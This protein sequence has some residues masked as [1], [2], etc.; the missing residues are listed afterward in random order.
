MKNSTKT[1]IYK[2]K[3]FFLFLTISIIN[4]LFVFSSCKKDEDS[5]L[6]LNFM[7]SSDN[8]NLDSKT[9]DIKCSTSKID[10]IANSKKYCPLGLL[11]DPIFGLVK[12]DMAFQLKLSVANTDFKGIK[13]DNLKSLELHLYNYSCYGDSMANQ[14]IKVYRLKK[15]LD[16]KKTYYSNYQF[17]TAETDMQFI[18][19]ATIKYDTSRV[20]KIQ[21]PMWLAEEFINSANKPHFVSD[22][23]FIE[24]F[25]GLYLTSDVAAAGSG[26]I[27]TMQTN[28][29]KSKL[30]MTYK[31]DSVVNYEF[32]LDAE[33]A[34]V[35]TLSRDFT[36]ASQ[37][38]QNAIN[39]TTD[40]VSSCFVQG[41]GGLQTKI[42][43]SGI[44]TL[45]KQPDNKKVAINR[46]KIIF[47]IKNTDIEQFP[48]PSILY[49]ITIAPNGTQ[50]LISDFIASSTVYDGTY[51]KTNN[52]YSFNVTNFVQEMV[53]DSTKIKDLYLLPAPERNA[54]SPHRVEFY[55]NSGDDNKVRLEILYSY[56]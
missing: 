33:K 36:S 45:F 25:K 44:D 11:Q 21:L 13:N 27:F 12:A 17:S 35:S 1:N 34:I 7:Q 23:T 56:R 41:L 19:D 54:A 29:A 47:K 16:A 28:S 5:L 48:S 51:N 32:L 20:I 55:G 39:N 30:V 38:I 2:L 9:F 3:R 46:A 50:T 53:K 26:C 4:I 15:D 8:I 6:G 43:F 42:S 52:T 49:L 24:Y 18:C 22:T 40:V 31:K 14:N 37:D 10:S